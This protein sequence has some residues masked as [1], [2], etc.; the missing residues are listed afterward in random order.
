LSVVK[1]LAD[2]SNHPTISPGSSLAASVMIIGAPFYI[3][4]LLL[5]SVIFYHRQF[6]LQPCMS[7]SY[8]GL[9]FMKYLPIGTYFH[10]NFSNFYYNCEFFGDKIC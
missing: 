3:K 9:V 10:H 7:C 5:Y 6:L 8:N 1:R 4:N 2:P